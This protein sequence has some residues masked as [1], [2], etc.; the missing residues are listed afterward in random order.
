[1]PQSDAHWLS[2]ACDVLGALQEVLTWRADHGTLAGRAYI[3]L[4]HAVAAKAPDAVVELD[5]NL[6]EWRLAHVPEGAVKYRLLFQ[7]ERSFAARRQP[8]DAV[9]A[10]LVGAFAYSLRPGSPGFASMLSSLVHFAQTVPAQATAVQQLLTSLAKSRDL[11][12]VEKDW[13]GDVRVCLMSP[14]RLHRPLGFIPVAFAPQTATRA[15]VQAQLSGSSDPL[16]VTGSAVLVSETCMVVTLRACNVSKLMLVDVTLDIGVLGSLRLDAAPSRSFGNVSPA[17]ML[18]WTFAVSLVRAPA[19]S[20]R[21]LDVGVQM[22]GARVVLPTWRLP[23]LGFFTEGAPGMFSFTPGWVEADQFRDAWAH[24]ATSMVCQVASQ[25]KYSLRGYV[26][27]GFARAKSASVRVG[28]FAATTWGGDALLV[29]ALQS[30]SVL[31]VEVRAAALE[32]LNIRALAEEMF[33]GGRVDCMGARW[34]DGDHTWSLPEACPA[35]FAPNE[36]AEKTGIARWQRMFQ[37]KAA[38]VASA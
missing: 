12:R 21:G 3:L 18:A 34:T 19:L 14:L 36:A 30:G 8:D 6:I 33:P 35:D 2:N 26:V 24:C 17:S 9:G 38:A 11:S 7:L 28:M 31:G 1:V 16:Y 13:L 37:A 27:P 5:N 25:A 29:V 10:A 20:Q 22:S 23:Y 32:G 15:P 4:L